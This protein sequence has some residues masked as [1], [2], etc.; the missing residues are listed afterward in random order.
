MEE[1]L[2]DGYV[3]LVYEQYNELFPITK[4]SITQE[5]IDDLYCLTFVMPNCKLHLS[6]L[7]PQEKHNCDVNGTTDYYVM[8]N[9]TGT[10]CKLKAGGTYYVYVEQDAKEL[11]KESMSK[12]SNVD[13][14]KDDEIE[15]IR[16]DG[17][18]MESCSCIY[19]N[20]CVDEYGCKDWDNRFAIATENGWKGF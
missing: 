13:L 19:G 3:T 6:S 11:L 17:R 8:E 9:P 16:D 12:K 18:V 20:P 5:I 2:D 1:V 15:I 4:G 7:S 10:F 14:I